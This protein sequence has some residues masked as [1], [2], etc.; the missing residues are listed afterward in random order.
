MADSTSTQATTSPRDLMASD[1]R[2]TTVR[3]DVL[4]QKRA[5]QPTPVVVK[6]GNALEF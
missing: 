3:T 4:R 2:V 5:E 6:V 1:G